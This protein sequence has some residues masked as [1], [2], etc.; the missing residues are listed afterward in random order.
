VDGQATRHHNNP[1]HYDLGRDV[2]PEV[3]IWAAESALGRR[4]LAAFVMR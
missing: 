4:G 1:N 3:L 2:A